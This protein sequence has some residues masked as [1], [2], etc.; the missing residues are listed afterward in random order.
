[1]LMSQKLLSLIAI[2]WSLVGTNSVNAQSMTIGSANLYKLLT[3]NHLQALPDRGH[4]STI[5]VDNQGKT[6][7]SITQVSFIP[8]KNDGK[9][10]KTRGAGSRQDGQCPQDFTP[11]A[12]TDTS[13]SKP[14]LTALVPNTNYGLTLAERPTFLVYLPKTS[15]KQVVLSIKE[16]GIKHHSQIFLPITQS[17]GIIRIKPSENTP[18]L[19]V[20]K[21]Y[22]WAVVLICG[23]RPSP[24]DPVIASWVRRVALPNSVSQQLAQK[25]SLEQAAWYGK[26]GIWYDFM[27]A[28]AQAKQLQFHQYPM[29]EIWADFLTSVG[30]EAISNETLQF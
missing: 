29:T 3:T 13:S 27:V 10:D 11:V 15:A 26:Q 30:L 19:E 28:L 5:F 4:S 23:E 14:F 6:D 20:N 7:Q 17:P 21:N 18:P 25:T 2:G 12:T 16:E 1:M 24:N 8:P 9:P 22:Q